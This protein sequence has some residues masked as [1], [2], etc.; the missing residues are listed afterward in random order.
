[1]VHK[2]NVDDLKYIYSLKHKRKAIVYYDNKRNKYV[3]INSNTAI[4]NYNERVYVEKNIFLLGDLNKFIEHYGIWVLLINSQGKKQLEVSVDVINNLI[5]VF[6]RIRFFSD[7]IIK[8]IEE[9]ASLVTDICINNLCV[10]KEEETT[11]RKMIY[12]YI[13]IDIAINGLTERKLVITK[14]DKVIDYKILR[15]LKYLDIDIN[16]DNSPE[17]CYNNRANELLV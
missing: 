10:S 4:A 9:K 8:K 3:D 6:E 5:L 15:S 2:Y 12:D 1:M 16:I 14:E 13:F 7:S 11:L 17:Y